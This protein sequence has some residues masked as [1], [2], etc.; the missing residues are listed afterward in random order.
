MPRHKSKKSKRPRQGKTPKTKPI[1]RKK[2]TTPK[3]PK[4]VRVDKTGQ[5]DLSRAIRYLK[6]LGLT[7]SKSRKKKVRQQ[8]VARYEDVLRGRAQAMTFSKKDAEGFRRSGYKKVGNKIIV[9]KEK[10]IRKRKRGRFIEQR[11]TVE[12]GEIIILATPFSYADLQTRLDELQEDSEIKALIKQGWRLSLRYYGNYAYA[13][14]ANFDLLR[15]YLERYNIE[16]HD[17]NVQNLE[18]IIILTSPGFNLPGETERKSQAKKRKR[19]RGN[20]TYSSQKYQRWK[21]RHPSDYAKH[22]ANVRK[23]MR[24]YRR[25][26]KRKK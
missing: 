4:F 9:P 8:I 2:I 1:R 10:K 24:K 14:M 22:K 20:Q 6:A 3:R 17:K 23:A 21:S 25:K 12:F 11:R 18:L 26:M 15:Q 7:K 19:S 5:R 13:T 16:G